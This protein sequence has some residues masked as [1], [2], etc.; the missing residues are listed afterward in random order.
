MSNQ[1][2]TGSVLASLI[3]LSLAI[4]IMC[5]GCI[6][7]NMNERIENVCIKRVTEVG[8]ADSG[9]QYLIFAK[10]GTVYRNGDAILYGKFNSSDIQAELDDKTCYRFRVV[11]IRS[12]FFSLYPNILEILPG[13]DK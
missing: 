2:S 11:G 5:G 10:D 12:H 4:I 9:S 7:N 3:V 1:S 6:A 8:N 13:E